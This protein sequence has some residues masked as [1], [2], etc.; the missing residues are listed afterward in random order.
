[1]KALD[2]RSLI[3]IASRASEEEKRRLLLDG[4]YCV[5]KN[6]R[7]PL[8]DLLEIF[9]PEKIEC[10]LSYAVT[11]QEGD[12]KARIRFIKFVVD[13]GYR[14]QPKIGTDGQYV[15]HRTT[16]I[17]LVSRV[18]IRNSSE[19]I[20]L[21]F[22]I[23]DRFDLNYTDEGG[24]THF[25]AA[26]S[27][28]IPDRHQL[29]MKFLEH[30]QNP[31]IIVQGYSLFR[32]DLH[33]GWQ[34]APELLKR[35]ADPTWV[36]ADGSTALHTI[37]R[38]KR[39]DLLKLFFEIVDKHRKAVQ[40]NV[41]DSLGKTPLHL[42][43]ESG[44]VT[45]FKLLL[46]RGADVNSVN[47]EGSTLLHLIC[48][49]LDSY[50]FV[51]ILFKIANDIGKPVWVNIQ[52]KEGNTPL[53]VAIS[54]RSKTTSKILLVNGSNP[55]LADK[56]GCTALHLISSNTKTCDAMRHFFEIIDDMQQTVQINARDNKGW[57][58]LHVA[59]HS[60]SRSKFQ[61]LLK[62][63]ADPNVTNHDGQTALHF[64]C[65]R[66]D[67][68][69][70]WNFFNIIDDMQQP[71]EIDARDIM[72]QT[73]LLLA[74]FNANTKMAE[75]LLWADA[76]PNLAD[77]EGWTPLHV[78]CIKCNR[79]LKKFFKINAERQKPVEINATT[80]EGRT[81]LKLLRDHMPSNYKEASRYLEA[82]GAELE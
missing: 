1:M 23:Y 45:T 60:G 9:R 8:P 71:V 51:E 76:D 19:I 40:I 82:L 41:R 62:R 13:T 20:H 64:V 37:C 63:G 44:K 16:P 26:C 42:A 35:G 22:K 73:P 78:I 79:F 29:V 59:V 15:L 3:S 80:I 66:D 39:V 74:L 54:H 50:K 68:G 38:D 18:K 25:H 77:N 12:E 43:V 30:K 65:R 6:W 81:P 7:G 11:D 28:P 46:T 70:M 5:V 53:H 4:I 52:D 72:G 27:I 75:H 56:D 69:F 17:H 34:L 67:Y 57:T 31:N 47:E 58:P 49:R 55:N 21:L 36:D 33:N 2:W 24:L 48:Q 32:L 61:L 14:D 10:L